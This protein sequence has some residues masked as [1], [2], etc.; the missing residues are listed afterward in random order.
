[1]IL[2]RSPWAFYQGVKRFIR[3]SFMEAS[4]GQELVIATSS[5][6]SKRVAL[7]TDLHER[8]VVV[9]DQVRWFHR[10]RT[11]SRIFLGVGFCNVPFV[12]HP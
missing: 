3:S 9:T 2:E 4:L 8:L 5:C 11:L 10:C 1:M 12:F 6:I 7:L